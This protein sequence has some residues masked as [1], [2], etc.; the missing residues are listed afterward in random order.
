MSQYMKTKICIVFFLF[1]LIE[2]IQAANLVANSPALF[3]YTLTG[4]S[5]PAGYDEAVAVASLQG[6]INRTS[7]TLYVK[8]AANAR[9]QTWLNIF[10]NTG[11]WL[12]GRDQVALPDLNALLMLAGSKVKGIVIWD[13][14]VPATINVATTIAGVED[15]VVLSPDMATTYVAQWEL[16]VIK[17]LLG[18]FTGSG[19]VNFDG[20]SFASSGSAKND[21]YR[22]AI[23]KYLNPGLCSKKF[24]CYY[25]DAFYARAGNGGGNSANY[26]VT[27][28]WAVANRSFVYD[29]SPWG[30]EAPTDDPGQMLGTDLATYTNMLGAVLNQTAG[31]MMTELCG[32]FPFAKYS[33]AFDSARKH[34]DVATEWETVYLISPY[35]IYQNTVAGSCF[36]QSLHSQAPVAFPLVNHRPQVTLPL[37]NKNGS[38]AK[39]VGKKA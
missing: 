6:L 22:W 3:T 2:A 19:T 5:T 35:N 27:R 16:P 23:Q 12:A 17:N 9:P 20:V 28:D 36:N 24:V 10:T 31:A 15:A 29:L 8:S 33:N 11:G 39:F 25:E 30:D 32:F 4:A 38:L 13:T 26:A 18:K 34:G 14:N 7:P 21:A 1:G 37:E